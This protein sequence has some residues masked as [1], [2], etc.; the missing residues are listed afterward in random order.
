VTKDYL[1][2]P[3]KSP[4]GDGG[5]C[6]PAVYHMLDV[7]AVAESLVRR[8][9]FDEPL[10]QALVLLATLHDLGKIGERFRA[11]IEDGAVQGD[12]HWQVS[13]AWFNH[14]DKDLL[15]PLLGEKCSRR[16]PLY[17][18]AAGHHGGPPKSEKRAWA[19]MVGRAGEE[20]RRDAQAFIADS[21]ALFPQASLAGLE[22]TLGR[23]AGDWRTSAKMLS[24]WFAGLVSLAD[25]VGSNVEWFAPT[26]DEMSIAD[27]WQGAREKAEV[28]L[29]ASGLQAASPS[30]RDAR[31][32]FDFAGLSPM[33]E[34]VLDAPVREGP[35]LAVIEDATGSGKTEAALMLAVRMMQAGK[36]DGIF[37]ALPTMATANAM[38]GRLAAMGRMFDGTPSRALA[39]SRAFLDPN[40]R[41]IVG[42]TTGEPDEMSCADWFADG[43]RKALF[44]QVGV[45]TIDQALLAVLPTRY[46]ALR[47]HALC[48]HILIV[49]EA[50]DY[51]PYMQAEL[52]AL[53]TFHSVLG[54]S[55][56]L[57]TATLP[58]GMRERL[59][60]AFQKGAWRD[61]PPPAGTAYPQL[62][63]AGPTAE[64]RP[65]GAVPFTRRRVV[66]ERLESLGDALDI[67][68]ASHGR[69]AASA[70]I[71]N[72]VDEAIA[73]VEALWAR[74]VPAKLHHARFAMCDRLKTEE[75]VLEVFGKR[76]VGREG[77]VIV[78]TQVLE[79]SLDLDFDVL[80]SDLAPMG[81]LIQRAGRL[82]RHMDLRPAE[83]RPVAGPTLHVLSPDPAEVRDKDWSRELLGR[84]W[85]VYPPPVQW[86]TASALFEADAIVAPEGLRALIEAV[87]GDDAPEVPECLRSAENEWLG[88]NAY[89]RAHAKQ[90][91]LSFTED[92]RSAAQVWSDEVYPTRLGPAT[93]TLVLARRGPNGDLMPWAEDEPYLARAWALS[94]VTISR[95]RWEQS[96][97]VNQDAPEFAAVRA[98]WKDW[99]KVRFAVCPV[100]EDGRIS[101][102]LG[103]DDQSGLV[104]QSPQPQG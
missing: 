31:S 17:A 63:V 13:M 69:G 61:T 50:H 28:A 57:M 75:K 34:A 67:L 102:S 56:I 48:R 88:A 29:G 51:D 52:E 2:W 71:R 74:G 25:W 94:E 76:G 92:Y 15:A 36:G 58:Q 53:L 1:R 6:H 99:Q 86:R 72:S 12:R 7:G 16:S 104:V 9:G 40:F 93:V 14:F 47:L 4:Q 3:G 11:M 55:A 42:R 68:A 64:S 5:V 35:M 32:L 20:A 60:A 62:T 66:V 97:G 87:D 45:G 8:A 54:G 44:A 41:E 43:R 101:H 10:T 33:Q 59:V 39:H 95:R 80:V 37:F 78:G 24:W 19:D 83:T 22:L 18:A 90:N 84:G 81:A 23:A 26:D 27:Y 79:S 103:Y 85:F 100:D 77:A 96:G 21:A 98:R 30:E 38:F 70:F 73:A 89:N 82:W 91:V 46:S 65:V 49:D